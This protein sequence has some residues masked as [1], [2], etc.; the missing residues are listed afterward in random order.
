VVLLESL[1]KVKLSHYRPGRDLGFLEVEAPECLDN[2]HMNVVRLSALRT[3]RLY[4]QEGILVLISESL[5]EFRKKIV[6]GF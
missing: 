4:L 1:I 5:I 2:L 6:F 3:G